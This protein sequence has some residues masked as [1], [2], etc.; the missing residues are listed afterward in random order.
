MTISLEWALALPRIIDN[1]EYN[2]NQFVN[3]VDI[4]FH[5]QL[6]SWSQV[7]KLLHSLS[8]CKATGIDKV[9]AKVLK[10]AAP[11]VSESRMQI[12]K[13]STVSH[14]IPNEW[15]V[16][17]VN[18]IHKKQFSANFNSTSTKHDRKRRC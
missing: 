18:A 11:V 1:N 3:R 4:S 13:K 2:F 9:S 14:V 5:F 12:F 8:V 17:R 10:W 6:V 15:K 16:A 7:Y